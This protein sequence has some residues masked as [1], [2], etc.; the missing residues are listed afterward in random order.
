MERYFYFGE[1][2]VATTGSACM[3]PLS[4][5]LGMT[6]GGA[7]S[8]TMHFNARNGEFLDD[9]VTVTHSAHTPKQFMTDITRFLRVNQKNP[10]MLIAEGTDLTYGD[11]AV[12]TGISVT[13]QA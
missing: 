3:F 12:I 4:S 1:S 5:F 8:T 6:P 13:T 10:F 9:T 11:S 2:T 7:N